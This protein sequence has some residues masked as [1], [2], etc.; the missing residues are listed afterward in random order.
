MLL[1]LYPTR[2]AF[3]RPLQ[4]SV[5][6]AN[7]SF[8]STNGV[9]HSNS[10]PQLTDVRP[11]AQACV[12][13]LLRNMARQCMARETGNGAARS[14]RSCTSKP[15]ATVYGLGNKRSGCGAAWCSS[16]PC[17]HP[18]AGVRIDRQFLTSSHVSSGRSLSEKTCITRSHDDF[19]SRCNRCV[20]P[21]FVVSCVELHLPEVQAQYVSTRYNNLATATKTI[22]KACPYHYN[23][24]SCF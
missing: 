23:M 1:F 8:L 20:K 3:R 12:N 14:A 7:P 11:S 13:H 18:D 4:M 24:L 10:A 17:R 22:I 16:S 15:A 9:Q 6:R 2:Q 19:P 21:L 5:R